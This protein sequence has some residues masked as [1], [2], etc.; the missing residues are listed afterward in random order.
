MKIVTTIS[1]VRNE[2]SI[3]R[4]NGNTISFVPTMG[5]LHN[6]HLSLLS[7]A[8]NEGTFVV[9]SIFV[10]RI[11]FND[12]TDFAK[13]PRNDAQDI[14]LAQSNG[15]DL[16]FIPAESELYNN[17]STFVIPEKLDNHLCGAS[18]SGHF[19]GVCTVVAKFFNIVQ[20]DCA[21]FG[22]KD[23]Q[24]IRILAK[25]VD[26]LH[27]PIRLVTAPTKR[28]ADGLAMSSRNI[29]LSEDDRKK[30]LSIYKSLCTAKLLISSGESKSNIIIKTI[31]DII[32]SGG[33]DKVDYISIVDYEML[34]PIER[35]DKDSVIAIAAFFGHTRLIDNMII[36]YGENIICE[37]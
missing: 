23:I 27:F 22:Q 6:G 26:D 30:A 16:L 1:E 18:R 34:Q 4:K 12:Q 15:C 20:P 17:Q 19:R 7:A 37:L 14:E 33:S 3:A 24:Q 11:Q 13:Y 5:A 32:V 10:N 25:M 21:V 31:E 28:E 35:I 8:R 9:M 2:I 29:H 36:R